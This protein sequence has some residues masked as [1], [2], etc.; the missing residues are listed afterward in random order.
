VLLFGSIFGA[1]SNAGALAAIELLFSLFV[2]IIAIAFHEY[3]T[4]DGAVVSLCFKP[5]VGV[6][7]V[8]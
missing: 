4:V 5:A 2:L 1:S 3:C 7:I 6:A 8:L